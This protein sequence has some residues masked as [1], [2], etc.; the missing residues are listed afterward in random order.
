MPSLGNSDGTWLGLSTS[1]DSFSTYG[2]L[3][4]TLGMI[5]CMLYRTIYLEDTGLG[6]KEGERGGAMRAQQKWFWHNSIF[7]CDCR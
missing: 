5:F 2:T 4:N 7:S 6:G 3:T 1:I